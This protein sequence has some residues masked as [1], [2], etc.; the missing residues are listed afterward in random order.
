MDTF[1]GTSATCFSESLR[2]THGTVVSIEDDTVGTTSCYNTCQQ[3]RS[4]YLARLSYW[5]STDNWDHCLPE[6]WS[7]Q[8]QIDLFAT[9]VS[10]LLLLLVLQFWPTAIP[11]RGSRSVT[12]SVEAVALT[13]VKSSGGRQGGRSQSNNCC[14]LE[15]G[16]GRHIVM[17]MSCSGLSECWMERKMMSCDRWVSMLS[18]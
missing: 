11:I 3:I 13:L 2:C 10:N 7:G 8:R 16:K 4:L 15:G 9:E 18:L 1:Q 14:T 17:T 12:N 6:H 5:M